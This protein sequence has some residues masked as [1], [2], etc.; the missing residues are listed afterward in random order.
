MALLAGAADA[1]W[2]QRIER[3]G[4]PAAAEREGRDLGTLVVLGQPT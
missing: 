4:E 1:P 3:S 2:G